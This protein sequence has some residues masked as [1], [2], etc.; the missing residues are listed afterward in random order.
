MPGGTALSLY[1]AYF[2]VMSVPDGK[3]GRNLE[4][5]GVCGV[6]LP[7]F[8]ADTENKPPGDCIYIGFSLTF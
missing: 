4:K 3:F 2:S 7:L 1:P 6:K 8:M 5:I